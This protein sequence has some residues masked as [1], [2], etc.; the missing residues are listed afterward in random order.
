MLRGMGLPRCHTGGMSRPDEVFRC[1]FCGKSQDEV[2]KLVGNP[3]YPSV[4]VYICDEC[5][6]PLPF[7]TGRVQDGEVGVTISGNPRSFDQSTAMDYHNGQMLPIPLSRLERHILSEATAQPL[8]RVSQQLGANDEEGEFCFTEHDLHIM[9]ESLVQR[10]RFH[11]EK[12]N[13]TK[14]KHEETRQRIW[15]GY[16]EAKGLADKL[17]RFL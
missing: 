12:F 13:E 15:K 17:R 14:R 1:S 3:A 16:E 8:P 4:R 11:L 2:K 9:I 7:D 10:S 5:I 6:R